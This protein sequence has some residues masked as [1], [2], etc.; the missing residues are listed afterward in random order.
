MN[1]QVNFKLTDKQS[2]ALDL[3]ISDARSIMLYGGSRS[4]KTFFIVWAIFARAAQ[5]KSR[6]VILR[7]KFNH[8]KRSLWLDTIPKVLAIAFPDLGAIPNKSDFYYLLPN[9]SE[10]WVG[11][12]DD[13]ERTEKILGTEYST[14]YFN[15]S[16]QIDYQS[17]NMAKT[18]L[19]EKSGLKKKLYY[20]ANPPKKSHWQYWVFEKKINPIDDEPL[21]NPD[22]YE[23]LLM[24][25]IDN[26]DNIDEEYIDMLKTLPE[27]ER[28]RF[29]L[30]LYDDESDGN[31]YYAFNR[32]NHVNDVKRMTGTIFAGLDF[33]V[34][35]MTCVIVQLIDNKINVLDE[36]YLNNSDT[37]KMAAEIKRLGYTGARLIPDSTGRNRKTSGQSDFDILKQ[38]GFVIESTHNPFVTDRV[39]NVNRLFANNEI[40]IDNKCKKLI[41]DLEKVVWKDNKLDQKTD[42]HLTHISDA[43]GYACYKLKP[44]RE[45]NTRPYTG[46]R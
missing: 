11:G 24:N 21:E 45:M 16:S 39:N 23:S 3:F 20:D 2:E 13:K 4:G 6:H 31:A 7:A 15:E 14:M 34:D 25:P 37:Y 32:D 30:G 17:M 38:A 28:N 18:R 26:M 43:L 33:N 8:A 41:G 40:M 36:I 12:L 10:I 1:E 29:L 44:F 19:A 46:R 22:Q 27:K 42:K 9:G 35:P 5:H